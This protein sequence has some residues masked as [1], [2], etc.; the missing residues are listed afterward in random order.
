MRFHSYSD[1]KDLKA[2]VILK[3]PIK[4]DIGAVYNTNPKNRNSLRA[5]AFQA[6]ERELVFDIDMTDYDEVRNCCRYV[7]FTFFP[8]SYSKHSG[9][10][11]CNKCWKFMTISIKIIDRVIRG[12]VIVITIIEFLFSK[13][14]LDSNICYGYIV[15]V[16]VYIVGYVMEELESCQWKQEEL[17]LAI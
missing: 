4:I 14:T 3:T 13:R 11:I 15:V 16:E 10:N 12:N 1:D 5:G 2:D 6:M 9:A 8:V 7:L 17:L